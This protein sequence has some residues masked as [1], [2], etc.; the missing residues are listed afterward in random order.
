MTRRRQSGWPTE[1]GQVAILSNICHASRRGYGLVGDL[2]SV[3][4]E[5]TKALAKS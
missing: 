5:P 3:V 4:P 1:R 2:F